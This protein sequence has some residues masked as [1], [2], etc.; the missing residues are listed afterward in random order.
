MLPTIMGNAKRHHPEPCA[1][2]HDL[3]LQMKWLL[4]EQLGSGSSA[5]RSS[6]SHRGSPP[7]HQS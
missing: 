4:A 1:D 2:V 7:D 6:T 5:V 3:L